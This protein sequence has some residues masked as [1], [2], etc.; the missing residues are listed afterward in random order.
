MQPENDTSGTTAASSHLQ[1]LSNIAHGSFGMA[2]YAYHKTGDATN[3]V[4]NGIKDSSHTAQVV[5]ASKNVY[6]TA[7]DYHRKIS[8]SP[9]TEQTGSAL[10]Y[11]AGATYNTGLQAYQIVSTNPITGPV[12]RFAG[13][14]IGSAITLN[15]MATSVASRAGR[16]LVRASCIRNSL[17]IFNKLHLPNTLRAS[18]VFA[19]VSTQNYIASGVIPGL[20]T[21]WAIYDG[22]RVARYC[23]DVYQDKERERSQQ[24]ERLNEAVQMLFNFPEDLAAQQIRILYFGMYAP[25]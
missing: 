9:I 15:L 6:S 17:W 19:G 13:A 4:V 10:R 21:A 24:A 18:A 3:Y 14:A 8:E 5:D 23:Y 25:Q 2:K 1:F 12:L 22:Y 7:K 16:E 20:F 11:M